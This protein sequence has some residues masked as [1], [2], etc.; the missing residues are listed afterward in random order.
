MSLSAILS[1]TLDRS[2]HARMFEATR[3]ELDHWQQLAERNERSASRAATR[4]W[5][6]SAVS[7]GLL[8]GLMYAGAR[9]NVPPTCPAPQQSEQ[10]DDASVRSFDPFTV[11]RVMET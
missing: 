10:T 7:V 8:F 1:D 11:S 2:P 6:L 4:V 3:P 9:L 5:I